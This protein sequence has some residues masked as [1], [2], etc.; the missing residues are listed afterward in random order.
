MPYVLASENASANKSVFPDKNEAM[1]VSDSETENAISSLDRQL[2]MECIKFARFNINFRLQTNYHNPQRDWRYPLGQEAGTAAV[3][4]GTLVNLNERAKGLSNLDNISISAQKNASCCSITGNA[5]RGSSSFVE[6]TENVLVQL[7]ARRSGFSPYDSVIFVKERLDAAEKLL[8][9]RAPLVASLASLRERT[10]FALHEKLY[11][12]ILQQLLAEF[13]KWSINSRE[14]AWR[15]NTFYALNT[16]Q[17]FVSCSSSI[18]SLCSYSNPPLKGAAAVTSIVGNSISTLSPPTRTMVGVVMR[19]YQRHNLRKTFAAYKLESMPKWQSDWRKLKRVIPDEHPQVIDDAV[20]ELSFL[21]SESNEIDNILDRES[22]RIEKLRRVAAQQAISG[23]L[24]G[25]ASLNRSILS[26]V[27]YYDYPDAP[28]TRNKLIFAGLISQT[29][30]QA[31][32]LINTPTAA[33][34]NARYKKKLA[35]RGELPEQILK[36]RL[37]TLDILESQ[38]KLEHPW[39]H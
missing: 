8:V 16:T 33:I 13:I 17:N 9:Q 23:P 11:R 10:I 32:S 20:D 27:A 3:F 35:K 26:A 6:L 34:L 29:A 22:T 2:Y 5:I 15:E 24:I 31:Y 36:K 39:V 38:L 28:E 7:K 30:G 18:L 1:K 37:A 14:V 12:Q 4:A 21:S 25:L 19:K